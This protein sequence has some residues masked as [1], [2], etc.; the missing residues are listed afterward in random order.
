[1]VSVLADANLRRPIL[2]ASALVLG[3]GAL[4]LV[5]L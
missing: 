2:A 5:A 1:M 3:A 4:S